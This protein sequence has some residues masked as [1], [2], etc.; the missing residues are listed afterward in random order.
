[1]EYA[2]DQEEPLTVGDLNSESVTRKKLEGIVDFYVNEF[3]SEFTND[4][5][6]DQLVSLFT[7][8]PALV[9]IIGDDFINLALLRGDCVFEG[10]Q[11]VLL[12]ELHGFAPYNTWSN[13]TFE[14]ALQLIAESPDTREVERVGVTRAYATRHGPGPLPTEDGELALWLNDAHNGFND[15][16]RQFRVGHLDLVLLRYASRV[17]GGMDSVAVTHLDRVQDQE[18]NMMVCNEYDGG[19]TDF[20]PLEPDMSINVML[21]EPVLTSPEV[22]WSEHI[23]AALG[24]PCSVESFGPRAGDKEFHAAL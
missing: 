14:N 9:D 8:M 21:A 24:V 2:N 12:D 15:W 3:G 19:R 17:C 4:I 5:P 11:G 20:Q 7:W 10:A 18:I 22:G 1:V 13:A 23:V 16:Q 6:F